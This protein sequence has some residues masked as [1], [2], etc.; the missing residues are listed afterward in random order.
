MTTSK[1]DNCQQQFVC[2]SETGDCNEAKERYIPLED[3]LPDEVIR[4][5]LDDT[6]P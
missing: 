1:C 2:Q 4:L 6:A 3:D 5:V